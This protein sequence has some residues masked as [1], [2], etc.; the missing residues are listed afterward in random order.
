[1]IRNFFLE[2]QG[3]LTARSRAHDRKSDGYYLSPQNGEITKKYW[4]FE[5]V[6]NS[7][8]QASTL[9]H[10]LHVQI[11]GHSFGSSQTFNK[12]NAVGVPTS[13]GF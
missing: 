12:S 3:F 5:S 9:L 2:S 10:K 7:D 6:L 11:D 4:E 8:F 13:H 1:M